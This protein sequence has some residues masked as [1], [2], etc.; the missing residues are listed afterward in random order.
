MY[1]SVRRDMMDQ[2]PDSDETSKEELLDLLERGCVNMNEYMCTRYHDIA[3]KASFLILDFIFD[4]GNATLISDIEKEYPISISDMKIVL[5]SHY[6]NCRKTFGIA[7]G[8]WSVPS[9]VHSKFENKFAEFKNLL[10]HNASIAN[11]GPKLKSNK[12][13]A[14]S[15]SGSQKKKS[16]QLLVSSPSNSSASILENSVVEQKKRAALFRASLLSSGSSSEYTSTVASKPG[17]TTGETGKPGRKSGTGRKST[18]AVDVNVQKE[19][20]NDNQID[21]V[22]EALAEARRKEQARKVEIAEK[23]KSQRKEKKVKK[24]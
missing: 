7:L 22:A 17:P 3:R 15:D 16:T 2:L 12:R 24:K 8:L 1:F 11:V 21:P 14:S 13:K 20:D 5:D 4:A 10:T 19:S 23:L 9:D 18:M 6:Q